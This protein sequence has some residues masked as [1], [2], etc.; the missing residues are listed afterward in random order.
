ML[1]FSSCS[2]HNWHSKQDGCKIRAITNIGLESYLKD[3]FHSD[4]FVR[5]AIIPFE[6]PENFSHPGN[7]SLH[8][9][10]ELA[11]MLHREILHHG[12]MPIVEIF[13]IDR[14]PGKREEFHTGN[15]KAIGLARDA[16]YDLVLVGYMQ[17]ITNPSEISI[18]TKIIDTTNG[19]TVWNGE[20]VSYVKGSPL[21]DKLTHSRL[22][23]PEVDHFHFN[24]QASTFARCTAN[25]MLEQKLIQGTLNK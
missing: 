24:K 23:T 16:G 4:Q 12:V 7:E 1:V 22:I 25:E 5:V 8:F 9:G 20:T 11:V 2:L 3:R 17:N 19:V 6:V 13:N 14:W 15:H 18:L 21:S 10:R